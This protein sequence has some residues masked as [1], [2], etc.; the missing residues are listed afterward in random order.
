MPKKVNHSRLVFASKIFV[1]LCIT[2]FLLA[3][4]L[5]FQFVFRDKIL[6]FVYIDGISV[7]GLTRDEAIQKIEG[8]LTNRLNKPIQLKYKDQIFT[9]NLGKN[10]PIPT[11]TD[12]KTAVTLAFSIGRDKF[13][14]LTNFRP[15]PA[16]IETNLDL[17]DLNKRQLTTIYQAVDQPA[18]N[19]Q[20]NFDGDTINVTPSQDGKVV[21]R[22]KLIAQLQSFLR[23]N[24]TPPPELEI[25]TA[26]PSLDYTSA[27]AMKKLLDQVKLNPVTLNAAPNL[28]FELDFSTLLGL[29][30]LPARKAI[31]TQTTSNENQDKGDLLTFNQDKIHSYLAD[32]AQKIDRPVEEPVF[33]VD[34][35]AA[36]GKGRVTE[37]SP[38]QEGW[39][40]N[41]AQSAKAI[42]TAVNTGQ[43]KVDLPIDKTAPKNQLTN[44]MGIKELIARGTSKYEGS[45]PNR[46]YN[47]ELTAKKLNG[48]LVAPGET[49]SFDQAVGDISAATGYKQAY[50][51]KS[52]RTVLDDGGG[53][54]QV[55]TTL[56]RAALNAGVPIIERTAHAYRVHYYEEDGPP[57]IDATI[58]YPSVDLKFKNDTPGYILIQAHASDD[59]TLTVDFY[60]SSDGRTVELTKPVISNQTPPPPDLRQDDPT[61]PKGEV[62]QVD[63]SAWG[64]NIYFKRRVTKGSQEL[65]NETFYSNFKPWQAIYLVGTKE[66]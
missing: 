61:L 30:E 27:L 52:G 62:K 45:I 3:S 17:N 4:L 65:I 9:L 64:A 26:H 66:S 55:S 31:L 8:V 1:L 47:V 50:V 35:T 39:T 60:G 2:L 54:C 51:I 32:L 33:V 42:A 22:E 5:S 21:D 53:V 37:F 18:I 10:Q 38:P 12:I 6:P 43:S 25:I 15:Q 58:F 41:L 57:G 24:Q 46:I 48:T 23:T 11:I 28:V 16:K 59:L 29:L 40:L 19:S 7:A 20:L 49:F 44:K 56:F 63:F 36:G 14:P 34:Q 13:Y